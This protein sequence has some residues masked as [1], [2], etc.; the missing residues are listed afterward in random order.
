MYSY[1]RSNEERE[2]PCHYCLRP[3]K[4]IAI[5]RFSKL[6]EVTIWSINTFMYPSIDAMKWLER[7]P[8][9]FRYASKNVNFH[10]AISTCRSVDIIA[11]ASTISIGHLLEPVLSAPHRFSY[12]LSRESRHQSLISQ[13]HFISV[14]ETIRAF[15][16]CIASQNK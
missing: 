2:M 6:L 11:E 12:P 1:A 9:L 15:F 7:N 4:T 8:T 5:Y 10:R 16:T 14:S 13:L 3:R